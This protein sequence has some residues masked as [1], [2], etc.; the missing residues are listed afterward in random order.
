MLLAADEDR[1]TAL[2]LLDLSA[3][4]DTIGHDVLLDRLNNC[5]GLTG[6]VLNWF[7]SYL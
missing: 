6:P 2:A 7:S 5:C 3:A 4:F 1:G